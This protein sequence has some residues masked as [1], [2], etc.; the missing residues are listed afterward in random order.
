MDAPALSTG[1]EFNGPRRKGLGSG[2]AASCV[3]ELRLDPFAMAVKELCY[4][5][6]RGAPRDD[7]FDTPGVEH[8]HRKA[9]C[10]A[11]LAH[12]PAHC[13]S[14]VGP[15]GQLRWDIVKHHWPSIIT[16]VLGF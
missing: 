8:P 15:Q 16:G 13:G 9:S 2:R 1:G 10:A 14:I 4:R 7:D 5:A 6:A 3:G 11:A 12:G